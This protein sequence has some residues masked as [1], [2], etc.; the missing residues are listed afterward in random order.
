MPTMAIQRSLGNGGDRTL[1]RLD[2]WKISRK[3]AI[4]LSCNRRPPEL[5][6]HGNFWLRLIAGERLLKS[7]RYP[8]TRMR[9]VGL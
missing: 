9:D 3:I 4:R 5:V 8:V 6:L 7:H 1:N 2:K